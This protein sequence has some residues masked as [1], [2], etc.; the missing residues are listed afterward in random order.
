MM[1]QSNRLWLLSITFLLGAS[2]ACSDKGAPVD[3]AQ[4]KGTPVVCKDCGHF[5]VIPTDERRTYPSDPQAGAYKC[6]QCG[7]FAARYA[8]QCPKCKQWYISE[9]R[10]EPCPHCAKGSATPAESPR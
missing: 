2:V 1:P 9:S 5:F 6:E 10:A 7:H 8:S 4:V 3:A